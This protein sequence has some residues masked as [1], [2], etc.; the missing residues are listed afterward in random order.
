MRRRQSRRAVP[1]TL[2]GTC[3]SRGGQRRSARRRGG[4]TSVVR[5]GRTGVPEGTVGPESPGSRQGTSRRLLGRLAHKLVGN[6]DAR[7]IV[8]LAT[9]PV[10]DCHATNRLPRRLQL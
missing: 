4:S 1:A 9:Q 8:Y 7:E 10:C 2:G 3:R 5:V 6:Q